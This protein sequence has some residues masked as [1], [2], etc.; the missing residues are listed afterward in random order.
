M[1]KETYKNMNSQINPSKELKYKTIITIKNKYN[2]KY[3]KKNKIL[4]N[5]LI[6]TIIICVLLSV[7]VIGA[8]ISYFDILMDS[9]FITYEEKQILTPLEL[10]S[11]SNGIKM[12]LIA[13][14]SDNNTNIM[15]IA[16]QDLIQERIDESIDLYNFSVSGYNTFNSQLLHYNKD[17]KT[18]IIKILANGGKNNI[19]NKNVKLTISSFLSNKKTY[20]DVLIDLNIDEIKNLESV[21][22]D[23][24][25]FSGGGGSYIDEFKEKSKIN[26]IKHNSEKKP[27]SSDIDFVY[28]TG[29]GYIDNMLHIQTYWNKSIDNHGFIYLKDKYNNKINATNISFDFDENGNIVYGN[30]YHE[31]IYKINKEDLKN[32]KIYGTFVKSDEY[33]EGNWNVK[34]NIN[35][36]D[37][38]KFIK[39]NLIVDNIKIDKLILSPLGIQI[40][41]KENNIKNFN[42]K[43][44]TDKNNIINFDSVF[45]YFDLDVF[46][47][48]YMSSEPINIDNIKEIIINNT[49]IPLN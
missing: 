38:A 32:Y 12:T 6:I 49:S 24:N 29:F 21:P 10:S 25:Y 17:T 19:F 41:G 27:I 43:I 34:F 8:V 28:I 26:I 13:S 31:F 23:M 11:E 35:S 18:A 7:P 1:F 16:L 37:K 9:N 30:N 46:N 39:K 40:T 5:K 2:N 15:Y 3:I 14:L 33:T 47:S 4:Y 36:V 44:V 48:K 42:I 20:E 45:S 22:M